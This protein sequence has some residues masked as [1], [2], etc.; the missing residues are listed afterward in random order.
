MHLKMEAYLYRHSQRGMFKANCKCKGWFLSV[1]ICA[2]T[3]IKSCPWEVSTE[4]ENYFCLWKKPALFFLPQHQQQTVVGKKVLGPGDRVPWHP[5]EI[6]LAH[7][8]FSAS[9]SGPHLFGDRRKFP[10]R[11]GE[12]FLAFR[13]LYGTRVEENPPEDPCSHPV[14]LPE[15]SL[16]AESCFMLRTVRHRL[17]ET[18]GLD[19]EYS[20]DAKWCVLQ[21]CARWSGLPLA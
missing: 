20:T 7:W 19:T 12:T 14:I 15:G 8:T 6:P 9:F 13:F 4:A 21:V 3:V 11:E 2:T 1:H 10:T 5:R 16:P 18:F 17:T